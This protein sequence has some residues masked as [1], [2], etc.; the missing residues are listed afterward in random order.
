MMSAVD[1]TKGGSVQFNQVL[2]LFGATVTI[3][4]GNSQVVYSSPFEELPASLALAT[5]LLMENL[6]TVDADAIP[7]RINIM[8]CPQEVL[9]GIPGLTDE[10]VEMILEARV[11]GS[12]S[13]TRNYE[14]WLAVEGILTMEEMRAILPLVTCGGDVFKAQIIG[15]MEGSNASSR[16]EAIVSGAGDVPE[17]LFFRRLDHLGRG[18]DISTL[19]QRFDATIAGGLIQ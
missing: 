18:A 16:I 4:Q 7:G 15:Y 6:T 17:V 14:T 19:G 2:D 9:R 1:M 12:E 10:V 11:D 3:Q 8:E 5:P 13:E